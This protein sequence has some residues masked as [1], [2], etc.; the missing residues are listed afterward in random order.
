MLKLQPVKS[1]I[2][3]FRR[4]A[5][6]GTARDYVTAE[7][8]RRFPLSAE[9]LPLGTQVAFRLSDAYCPEPD[10]L[11]CETTPDVE[12]IGEVALLSAA[13]SESCRYAVIQAEGILRPIIVPIEQLR[14]VTA[15]AG[16][17]PIIG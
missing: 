16:I 14:T 12:I 1:S 8:K 9:T 2:E 15:G 10:R 7:G 3:I 6:S 17:R 13:G 5:A 4:A 11:L